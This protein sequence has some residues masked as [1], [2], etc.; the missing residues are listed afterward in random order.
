[1]NK[2][3]NKKEFWS[4]IIKTFYNPEYS[5]RKFIKSYRVMQSQI[6]S[7]RVLQSWA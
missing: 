6:V 5:Q 4:D 1:M 3:Q 2:N 7:K